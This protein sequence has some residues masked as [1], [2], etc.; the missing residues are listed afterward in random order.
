MDLRTD[1]GELYDLQEDPHEMH[2]LFGDSGYAG[3][4]TEHLSMI[5]SRPDDQVP[6]A[7]RVGWH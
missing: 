6:V 3:I 1:T 7:P 2:N 5:K 4:Q